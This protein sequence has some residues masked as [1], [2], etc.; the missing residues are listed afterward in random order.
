MYLYLMIPVEADTNK[1]AQ[2]RMYALECASE[3][4]SDV[5]PATLDSIWQGA[6]EDSSDAESI[7][8]QLDDPLK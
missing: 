7:D 8:S 3:S 2:K 4:D 6:D 1:I 5:E